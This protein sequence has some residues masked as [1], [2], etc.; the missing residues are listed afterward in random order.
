MLRNQTLSWSTVACLIVLV[1]GRDPTSNPVPLRSPHP[2]TL[3]SKYLGF[4]H[5]DREILLHIYCSGT[6]F[7][8]PKSLM[9][10]LGSAGWF[11]ELFQTRYYSIV[12]IL[13]KT[14]LCCNTISSNLCCISITSTMHNKNYL[15]LVNKNMRQRS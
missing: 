1:V 9:Y 4:L 3:W 6:V 12:F 5:A 15:S 13:I 10:L 2:L 11:A 7:R 14:T 8:N